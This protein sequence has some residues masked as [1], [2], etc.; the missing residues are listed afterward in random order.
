LNDPGAHAVGYFGA[1]AARWRLLR[2]H[3]KLAEVRREI[4]TFGYFD[5]MAGSKP[6]CLNSGF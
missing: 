5:L 3:G 4:D 6:C 2:R 1:N